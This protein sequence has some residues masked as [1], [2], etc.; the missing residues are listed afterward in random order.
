V[1]VILLD[2]ERDTVDE[3]VR[4]ILAHELQRLLVLQQVAVVAL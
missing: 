1:V 2:V 3:G 4:T